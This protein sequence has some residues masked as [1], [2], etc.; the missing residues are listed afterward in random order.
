[1]TALLPIVLQAALLQAVPAASA[2]APAGTPASH[3]ATA[4]DRT[5][6][7]RAARWGM[8]VEEVL[9]AFPREARR[10]EPPLQLAD[11]AVVA[12]EIPG[13]DLAGQPVDA[14]FVFAGG[15]LALVSLRSPQ[16]R[17]VPADTFEKLLGVLSKDFGGPG[18]PMTAGSVG[19]LRQTTWRLARGVAEL[20][21]AQGVLVL[22][23]H[24]AAAEEAGAAPAGR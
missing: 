5:G 10:M 6:E 8:T 19:E 15:K 9:K 20:K 23:Y 16:Q 12:A 18:E 14:R 22:Q 7:W 11:G 4:V 13:V 1:M 17:Y 2:T 3:A 24:P 21:Y